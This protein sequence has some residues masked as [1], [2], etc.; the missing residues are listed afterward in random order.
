MDSEPGKDVSYTPHEDVSSPESARSDLRQRNGA[1]EG[2]ETHHDGPKEELLGG[3]V[4][5]AYANFGSDVK[6]P[7]SFAEHGNE[8]DLT[9]VEEDEED[10]PIEEVRTIVQNKDDP[11]L[12]VLTFRFWLIGI[13]FTCAFAFINQFFWFRPEPLQLTPLVA[14]LLTY[15]MGK[16]LARVI[17]KSRFFNPGPF[18]IK[19]HVMVVAMVNSCYQTA[20]AVDIIAIQ[21]VF[22][23]QDIGWGGGL[24]LIWTTQFIG[25]GLAGFVRRWLVYPAAIV[26]PYD[27][28]SA[29]LL[30]S[31]HD[32]E[33]DKASFFRGPT[34]LHFFL[35]AMTIQF[36]YYWIPWYFF[37]ALASF[38][39]VCWI[40][41]HNIILSQLTSTASGLGMLGLSFDWT[42]VV[43]Y[44]GSPLIVP[45]WAICNIA[46]GFVLLAWVLVPILHYTNTWEAK[47]YP[48]ISSGIYT[49]NGSRYPVL[50][51]LTPDRVLNATAYEEVGPVRLTAFFAITYAIGF[52]G[53]TS[54]LMHT[55]LYHGREIIQQWKL[56]R[57]SL[58]VDIHTKLMRAYPETPNWW[59]AAVFLIFF[60]LSF[61]VIYVSPIELPWWGIFLSTGM[62]SI[63]II[64]I[65]IITAITNQTPGLNVITEF[66]IGFALPGHPI[67]NVTFKTYGYISMVQAITFLQDLKLG[68][69]IKVPPKAMFIVQCSG[70]FLAGIVNLATARWILQTPGVCETS[71]QYTCPNAKVFYS[72]SVIWGV[73]GPARQFAAGSPY[74]PTLYFFLIGFLLPIPFYLAAR[75]WPNS[76]LK[77]VHIPLIFNATGIMPPAMPINFSMWIL[78]GTIFMYYLRRY[79]HAWWAKYNYVF[80]ASQDTG[81]ALG[82]LF[83]T[84]AT[85]AALYPTGGTLKAMKSVH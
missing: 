46:V 31:F 13:F 80:S 73:I 25:Y 66:I 78:V 61:V 18:N 23:L 3:G 41:P 22:Y 50:S 2:L 16:F 72:A 55:A 26:W 15:P 81:A 51:V 76:W 65:G 59:Y 56:S 21:K 69:Y 48:I 63:F 43:A 79:H 77:Y 57:T 10:S 68:H 34:R 64:P 44:L 6:D 84:L 5:N 60:C 32:K 53:L 7:G 45:W 29:S 42:T 9:A 85:F 19:E 36:I 33:F 71:T 62:S 58:N 38:A 14:Q 49:T 11:S 52:A 83:T 47:T 67:A 17:P 28:V 27:L 8:K 30:R 35:I 75:R 70:T 12:P 40:N 1:S 4:G 82:A 39:W 24:L 74:T 54:A 37:Y 20:Y